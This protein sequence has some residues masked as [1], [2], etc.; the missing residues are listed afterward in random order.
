MGKTSIL[1][2]FD[3]AL[4]NAVLRDES[5]RRFAQDDGFVGSLGQKHAPLV[6][7][8]KQVAISWQLEALSSYP[9]DIA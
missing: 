7:V 1:G 8:V 9:S 6:D 5:V 4:I 3:S 2:S